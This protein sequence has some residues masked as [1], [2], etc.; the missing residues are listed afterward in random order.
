[1]A[2]AKPVVLFLA[3]TAHHT[4]AVADHINA[5]TSVEAYDWVVMNPLN[6]RV[7]HKTD[8]DQFDAIG[9]HYSIRPHQS[10]YF[11]KSLFEAVSRFKGIKFLFLQDEYQDVNKAQEAI[12]SL[13]IDVFFTLLR[14]EYWAKGYPRLVN[15]KVKLVNTLTA[16][17]PDEFKEMTQK[18]L[19]E[20]KID[21]FYRGREYEFWLG[22]LTHEKKEIVEGFLARQKQYALKLNISLKEEDRLYGKDWF[23][24]LN[25]SRCVLATESGASVWD[26]NGEAKRAVIRYMAKHKNANFEEVY[27]NVLAPFDGIIRYSA[28]SPRI[29]E[30]IA[31]GTVLIMFPGVYDNIVKPGIHYIELKRDFSNFDEVVRKLNDDAYLDEIKRRALE[32]V[33]LSEKYT[34]SALRDKMLAELFEIKLNSQAIDSRSIQNNLRLLSQRYKWFNLALHG[35]NEGRFAVRNVSA[36]LFDPRFSF[37]QKLE[38]LFTGFKRYLAYIMPRMRF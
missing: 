15:S 10:Y 27:E 3:N 13:G 12:L 22:E 11:P 6:C 31:V 21:V 32:D 14:E 5:I 7:L 18:P 37:Y 1:M 30:A 17:V 4:G 33:I 26:F 28:I 34:F 8:L 19:E 29:F 24:A 9:I 35:L 25:D 36:I 20:R 2:R 16:Y 23:D 38:R